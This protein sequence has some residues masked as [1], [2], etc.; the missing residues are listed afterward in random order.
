[1]THLKVGQIWRLREDN[2]CERRTDLEARIR[3]LSPLAVEFRLDPSNERRH[4]WGDWVTE[5]GWLKKEF[6]D[7][8]A[9]LVYEPGDP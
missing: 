4:I 3:G 9:F 5:E 1:M 2:C 6:H 7:D 8:N